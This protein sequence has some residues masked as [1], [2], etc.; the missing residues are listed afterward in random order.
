MAWFSG[1]SGFG[2]LVPTVIAVLVLAAITVTALRV[3]NV[4]R[5]ASPF[6]AILRGS[7][8]LAA[9]SLVLSGIISNPWWV[10]LGLVVMFV[11]AVYTASRRIRATW[12]QATAVGTA[13]LTG[14]VV[15]LVV[16][17]T[18]GAI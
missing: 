13:M 16:V 17:F 9:L 14:N 18:T 12:A 3:S 5:P 1:L 6:W 8:Q 10:A 15:V 11:A 2:A 4:P 7:L